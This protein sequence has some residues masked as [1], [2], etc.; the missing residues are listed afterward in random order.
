MKMAI[1]FTPHASY[2]LYKT[3]KQ[4]TDYILTKVIKLDIRPAWNPYGALRDTDNKFVNVNIINFAKVDRGGGLKHLST[5]NG[6]FVFYF[7]PFP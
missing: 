1:L 4:L 3:F 6:N 7:K 2:H 5:K